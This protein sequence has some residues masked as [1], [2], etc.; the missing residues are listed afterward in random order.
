MNIVVSGWPGAGSSTLAILLA[1]ILNYKLLR[2]SETFR[3]LGEKLGYNLTGGDRIKADNY[4]E[5]YWAPMYD[6]YI[7]HLI[8]TKREY[9]L[10]SDIAAFRIG[11]HDNLFSIFLAPSLESRQ[12]RLVVD[13]RPEEVELLARRQT[14]LAQ[15]YE[16]L[17]GFNWLDLKDVI[18]K[19][20]LV[21]DSSEMKISKELEYIFEALDLK[22]RI[23]NSFTKIEEEF[24]ELG[25]ERFLQ[26]LDKS[27][28]LIATESIIKEVIKLSPSDAKNMPT[29]LRDIACNV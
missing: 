17:Y 19:Y 21:I 24:W 6:K 4:L 29:E 25:K 26:I 28:L 8:L 27:N 14:D 7:D 22:K 1:H 11:L 20:N 18:E 3:F 16:K 5:K 10:E 13:G 2:G 15:S 12:K 9:I 23:V